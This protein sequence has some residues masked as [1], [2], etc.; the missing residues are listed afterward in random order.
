MKCPYCDEEA[1]DDALKCQKCGEILNKAEY[2]KHAFR[3]SLEDVLSEVKTF[4]PLTFLGITAVILFV[5]FFFTALT[6]RWWLMLPL[7]IGGLVAVANQINEVSGLEKKACVV[8]LWVAVSL[9]LMRDILLSSH[10]CRLLQTDF[11]TKL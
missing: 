5:V 1:Q 6:Y 7:A 4:A 3:Y 9:L 11:F 2:S 8:A 10:V